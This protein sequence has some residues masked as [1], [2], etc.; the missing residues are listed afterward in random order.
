MS[1]TPIRKNAHFGQ[2]VKT[3]AKPFLCCFDSVREHKKQYWNN[4]IGAD[5]WIGINND[6]YDIPT[7]LKFDAGALNSAIGRDPRYSSIIDTKGETNVHGLFKAFY[8]EHGGK[9]KSTRVT[10]YYVTSPNT[11]PQKPGG[12]TKWYRDI[13]STVPK[14]T[15]TRQ[16]PTVKRSV[17]CRIGA[18]QNKNNK[19]VVGTNP[20]E[21]KTK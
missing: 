9:R 20:E 7:N 2:T 11:L 19:R 13:V 17:P 21:E 8:Y 18:D 6:L 1:K 4:W 14:P 10:S 16:N 15:N 12:N 5:G 3:N